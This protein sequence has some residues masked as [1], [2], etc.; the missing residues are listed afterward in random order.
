MK[1]LGYYNGK[2]DEIERM[3]IPMTDR[4]CWFGDGVYDATYTYH[5][6]I[7]DLEAHL[8]RFFNSAALL[9]IHMP[10]EKEALASLLQELVLK[11]DSGE[12]FVY[13]QVTRGSGLRAHV[14]E[15]NMQGNLWITLEPANVTDTYQPIDVITYPDKRFSYCHIK[16]LN[17]IPACLA[18]TAAKRAGCA[19]AIFVRNGM[20]TECAHSNVSIFKNDAL[21][22]H[23][24]DETILPGTARKR[25]IEAAKRCGYAVEERAFNVVE[26]LQADEVV[27]HSSGSFCV[28]V[29]SVDGIAVGGKAPAMLKTLQDVLVEDFYKEC[30]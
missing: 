23:P 14:Y 17:L 27:V 24:L 3:H 1:N 12:Q 7:F 11:V 9:D 25:L 29:K 10:I 26:L 28:P 13:M 4:V 15:E 18:I 19:E 22:T 20:I 16:T 6:H 8:S 2:Y 21:I 5:H 30:Q